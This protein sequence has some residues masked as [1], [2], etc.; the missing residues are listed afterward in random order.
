MKKVKSFFVTLIVVA[1]AS[2]FFFDFD[3][4]YL[5]NIGFKTI[6]EEKMSIVGVWRSHDSVIEVDNSGGWLSSIHYGSVRKI[7]NA[8]I[9]SIDDK[10]IRVGFSIIGNY[11]EHNGLPKQHENGK[12]TWEIEGKIY[13][14][15]GERLPASERQQIVGKDKRSS[16]R[17]KKR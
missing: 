12:W 15:T 3:T 4:K 11:I 9:Q 8:K 14:K 2:Y 6:P 16:S 5:S 13:E 1:A 7:T 17:D 10:K